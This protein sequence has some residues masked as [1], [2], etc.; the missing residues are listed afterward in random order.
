M[1]IAGAHGGDT[2]FDTFKGCQKTIGTEGRQG[3]AARELKND[4]WPD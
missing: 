1:H 3:V 4:G 2:G